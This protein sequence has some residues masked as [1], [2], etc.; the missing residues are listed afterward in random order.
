[1]FNTSVFNKEE[2]ISIDE[3]D[4]VFVSDLFLSDY[5]GGAELTTKLSLLG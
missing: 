4:I 2:N 1:M 5:V 3:C